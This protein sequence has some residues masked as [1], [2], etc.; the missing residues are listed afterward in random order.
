MS[1]TPIRV[2]VVDDETPIVEL[3]STFFEEKGYAVSGFTNPG[4]ARSFLEREQVDVVF[5]DL[6][7]PEV[8]G[9]DI[10]DTVNLHQQDAL[11]V[12]F[13]GYAS[14]D[15]AIRA[16]QQG[17]YD[18]IRK[19]FKL[20]EIQAV[21]NRAV[22][23]LLLR[24]ENLRLHKENERMLADLTMLYDI[25]SIMYQVLDL[26]VIG[27]MILDT[28]TEGIHV[29]GV[30]LYLDPEGSR[31]FRHVKS[32][33]LPERLTETTLTPGTLVNGTKVPQ[34]QV[35]ILPIEDRRLEVNGSPVDFPAES[36]Y[37]IS[38][39][40]QFQ[41]QTRGLLILVD[42]RPN[43]TATASQVK[44]YQVVATQIAPV[45]ARDSQAQPIRN[46]A[47][48]S[49]AWDD[50][51]LINTLLDDASGLN[52][53]YILLQVHNPAGW[54]QIPAKELDTCEALL[55]EAFAAFPVEKTRFF[56]YILAAVVGVNTVEAELK[57]TELKAKF[58]QV[59]N[60]TTSL[61]RCGLSAYPRDGETASQLL[62]HLLFSTY[63]EFPGQPEEGPAES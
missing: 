27:D 54:D 9:L 33:S 50:Q 10:V 5:T 36:R 4:E 44:L 11:V 3:L 38:V 34:N 60:G 40:I 12:I 1:E 23:K 22:E 2:C 29:T 41:N 13:T 8:T 47:D 31:S 63:K 24:R 20:E 45:L 43:L 51:S 58:D 30:G 57:L 48:R 19:P 15:S 25:S 37:W 17:V 49:W 56:N 18:Y 61:L 39:P 35:H 21:L 46:G 42:S 7:M 28:L 6:K 26:D 53:A 14:I 52:A 55:Q 62:N 59:Y 16:L 32:R